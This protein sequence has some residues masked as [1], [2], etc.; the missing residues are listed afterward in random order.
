L[1]LQTREF[2][3]GFR[4][5]KP[6]AAWKRQVDDSIGVPREELFHQGQLGS[7]TRS[8]AQTHRGV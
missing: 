6:S 7:R 8:R 5:D 4:D 3:I 1:G 2:K